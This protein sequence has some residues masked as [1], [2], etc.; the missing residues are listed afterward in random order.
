MTEMHSASGP[1]R[2]EEQARTTRY[3]TLRKRPGY[4]IRLL[5]QIH[6]GL[7]ADEMDSEDLTPVQYAMLSVLDD[8]EAFDQMTLS[9]SVGID[10]AN[11]ADVIKRLVGRD[12]VS[13]EVSTTD[14]RARVVRITE[15]GSALV[16]QMRPAMERAQERLV[17]PLDA[18]E[19]DLLIDMLLRMI[20]TNKGASRA[21]IE[22]EALLR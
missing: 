16:R 20:E 21:P 14:R 11:G 18:R 3:A 15:A 19:R 13:R 6:T 8:G 4:L 17:S 12:L 1:A 10:R 22:D 2:S 9:R 7:F 5:H